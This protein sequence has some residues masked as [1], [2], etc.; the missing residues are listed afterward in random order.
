VTKKIMADFPRWP[1][2]E[3]DVLRDWSEGRMSIDRAAKYLHL[4]YPDLL[5]LAVRKGFSMPTADNVRPYPE[6]DG[7]EPYAT[8]LP[9]STEMRNTVMYDDEP[10]IPQRT[11]EEEAADKVKWDAIYLKTIQNTAE[12]R[13]ELAQ[14]E[15]DVR[16]YGFGLHD[17]AEK[18]KVLGFA[19]A[20]AAF[21]KVDDAV[22]HASRTLAQA[23]YW[24]DRAREL[25]DQPSAAMT[26]LNTPVR[27]GLDVR[28][29]YDREGAPIWEVRGAPI[30]GVKTLGTFNSEWHF[31][32]DEAKKR[33]SVLDVIAYVD[34]KNIHQRD[35]VRIYENVTVSEDAPELS[36][37][38]NEWATAIRE[39][40]NPIVAKLIADYD[41]HYRNMR[42]SV[43]KGEFDDDAQ[44][45][46]GI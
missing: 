45:F 10:E 33:E 11:P 24:L 6:T 26:G 41:E 31:T 30:D 18:A 2:N 46:P 19:D 27:E 3:D 29:T 20:Q 16:L 14:F 9:V 28:P 32:I 36:W 39:R 5:A 13:D 17:Y 7:G 22:F 34:W 12:T 23:I 8:E 43:E 15:E 37:S 35:P 4:Q 42:E 38:P 21:Q 1:F 25:V 40:A 44:A